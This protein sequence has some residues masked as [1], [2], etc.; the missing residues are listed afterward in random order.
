MENT[1]NNIFTK[2]KE[3]KKLA[4]GISGAVVALI[5]VVLVIALSGDDNSKDNTTT[6]TSQ[7][8]T[9]EETTTVP[10]STTEVVETTTP[11]ETTTEVVETITE[12]PTTEA[13]TVPETTTKAPETTT[14]KPETT[15][16]KPQSTEKLNENLLPVKH[17]EVLSTDFEPVNPNWVEDK[18]FMEAICGTFREEGT[19]YNP[20]YTP[21]HKDL[22]PYFDDICSQW[23]LGKATADDIENTFLKNMCVDATDGHWLWLSMRDKSCTTNSEP[24]HFVIRNNRDVFIDNYN[25]YK[26]NIDTWISRWN[27][28]DAKDYNKYNAHRASVQKMLEAGGFGGKSSGEYYFMRTYLDTEKDV[29]HI[30]LVLAD[31]DDSYENISPDF[32]KYKDLPLSDNSIYRDIYGNFSGN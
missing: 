25:T 32:Q 30:Y 12:E 8:T 20:Y 18:E 19:G 4:L 13:T 21:L 9:V 5:A 26:N 1:R 14:K 10:E 11:E 7:T 22:I 23:T 3:N 17:Y 28:Q 27:E 15:T 24:M 29:Y 16:K 2:L 31:T 6:T